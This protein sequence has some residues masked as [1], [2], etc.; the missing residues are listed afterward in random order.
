[1]SD[2][3]PYDRLQRRVTQQQVLVDIR[4]ELRRH[5][6]ATLAL[7]DELRHRGLELPPSAAAKLAALSDGGPPGYRLAAG[8]EATSGDAPVRTEDTAIVPQ[9]RRTRVSTFAAIVAA[10]AAAGH[11]LPGII[12]ILRHL[13]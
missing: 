7:A 6:E 12:E 5:T 1:M 10:A 8:G 3:T 9:P 13:F 4:D 11:L 2:D